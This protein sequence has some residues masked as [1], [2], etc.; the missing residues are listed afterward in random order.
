MASSTDKDGKPNLE[1]I[2]KIAKATGDKIL[3][4]D[5]KKRIENNEKLKN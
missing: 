4:K 1:E 2:K 5:V 3:E